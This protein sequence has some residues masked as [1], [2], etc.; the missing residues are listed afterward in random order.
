LSNA[1]ER[2]LDVME[3]LTEHKELRAADLVD[4]LEVSRATAFRLLVTLEKRGYVEQAGERRGWRL[5][6]A[7]NDL[8]AAAGSDDIAA[9]AS[10]ALAD[11]HHQTGETIN[12]AVYSRGRV[13]YTATIESRYPLHMT[14]TVGEEVPIHATAIGKAILAALPESDW[15]RVLPAEP[16]PA[17]TPNTKRGLEDLVQDLEHARREGWSLDLEECELSGVCVAA[18]VLAP[19]GH[20]VAA[21][22]VSSVVGRLDEQQRQ[23]Y[24]HAVKSWCDRISEGISR[25]QR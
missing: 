12:L 23:E 4:L 21:I 13:M 11:L 14:T 1:L 3:L 20:P 6:P 2:G 17:F 10:P 7:V 16:Y 15:R 25:A 9:L 5:G 19:T 8:A 18:A 22:S 24:G